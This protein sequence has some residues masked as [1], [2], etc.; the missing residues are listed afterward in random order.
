MRASQNRRGS[1]R[2]AGVRI[3]K[4][5]GWIAAGVAPGFRAP[6]SDFLGV[7]HAPIGHLVALSRRDVAAPPL[8]DR[9][10][11]I[12]VARC[13]RD[14]GKS[15]ETHGRRSE[16]VWKTLQ[17]INVPAGRLAWSAGA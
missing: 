12:G 2:R 11:R 1:G 10:P 16:Y 3:G 15:G 8:C 5:A 13:T 7:L 9:S 17:H 6:T 14:S 4:T